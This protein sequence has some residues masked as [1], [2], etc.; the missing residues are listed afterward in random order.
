MGLDHCTRGVLNLPPCVP[1]HVT[2]FSA[3][4]ALCDFVLTCPHAVC[5]Q[6]EL[7]YREA[8]TGRRISLGG[9]HADTL[10]SV[11]NLGTLLERLEQFEEAEALC[12]EA[13]AGRRATMPKHHKKTLVAV[14]NLGV[15]LQSRGKLE[16]AELLCQV[17]LPLCLHR[18]FLLSMCL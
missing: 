2:S 5:F 12:R 3:S 17:A 15:L 14:S 9:T 4:L 16:E 6:A 18:P 7:L 10:M 11:S 13:L 8:L 1:L